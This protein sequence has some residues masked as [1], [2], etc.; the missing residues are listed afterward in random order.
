MS[1]SSSII[2][3]ATAIARV[4]LMDRSRRRKLISGILIGILVLFALGNWPLV[5]WLSSSLWLMIIWWGICTLLCLFLLMLALYDALSVVKE[6]RG[7]M[8]LKKEEDPNE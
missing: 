8:G 2:A 7:K 5:K 6:E 1:Q 3:I 4:T